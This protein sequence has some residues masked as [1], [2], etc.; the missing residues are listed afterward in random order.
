LQPD[1]PVD[2]FVAST[3]GLGVDNLLHFYAFET[4]ATEKE[5]IRAFTEQAGLGEATALPY[6][7]AGD[8]KMLALFGQQFHKGITVTCPGFYGPQGRILRLPVSNPGLIDRLTEFRH[9]PHRISNFEMETS[10]IFGLGNLLGHACMSINVIIANRVRKE[11]SKDSGKA[12]ENLIDA[13]IAALTQN[14]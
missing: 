6:L 3:H 1:I 8:A 11:F 9:G 4:G 10:A 5:I 2:G 7:F 12:V 13:G 14:S